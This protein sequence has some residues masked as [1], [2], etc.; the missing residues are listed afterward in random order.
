MQPSQNTPNITFLVGNTSVPPTLPKKRK[1]DDDSIKSQKQKLNPDEQSEAPK[2]LETKQISTISGLDEF[3]IKEFSATAKKICTIYQECMKNPS[4]DDA[5]EI[6]LAFNKMIKTHQLI[7][8]QNLSIPPLTYVAFFKTLS[9]I[10]IEESEQKGDVTTILEQAAAIYREVPLT[11]EYALAHNAYLFFLLTDNEVLKRTHFHETLKKIE[12]AKIDYSENLKQLFYRKMFELCN[13]DLSKLSTQELRECWSKE[14]DNL[15]IK[16]HNTTIEVKQ[17]PLKRFQYA[18]DNAILFLIHAEDVLGIQKF[19]QALNG[20]PY[21]I[22][23]THF[24][25][26]FDLF[27][28]HSDL[29]S[30]LEFFDNL[31]HNKSLYPEFKIDDIYFSSIKEHL[32]NLVKRDSKGEQWKSVLET[33]IPF[34]QN[35]SKSL[36]SL[37]SKEA[38]I[39]IDEEINGY[40]KIVLE[41]QE[42][43]KQDPI[44]AEIE[45][46]NKLTNEHLQANE[47]LL[48]KIAEM[49][50]QQKEKDKLRKEKTKIK[51]EA[52][53]AK[54]R[55]ED[56]L[57]NQIEYERLTGLFIDA[58]IEEFNCSIATRSLTG[59]IKI[60][61]EKKASNSR[62]ANIYLK[63]A[64]ELHNEKIKVEKKANA[65]LTRENKII[66]I[67]TQIKQEFEKMSSQ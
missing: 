45:N 55:L 21:A 9:K 17:K 63:K 67:L 48:N 54:D 56:Q 66:V 38:L 36:I 28:K 8:S 34:N 6:Y 62:I 43:I 39:F 53:T 51:N 1:H 42:K 23:Y 37:I 18:Y 2:F 26:A 30:A 14:F 49:K 50:V 46:V 19:H 12:E 57:D 11:P 44:F 41:K 24:N 20:C 4:I 15:L 52:E 31:Q 5:Q 29:K 33:C 40:K 47:D 32:Q 59:L 60:Y 10:F 27:L 7:K 35:G 58:Q 3:N 61:E 22:C 16:I 25:K 13:R 65:E 64:Q